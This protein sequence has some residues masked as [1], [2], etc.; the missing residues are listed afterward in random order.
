M[1][2]SIRQALKYSK[3]SDLISKSVNQAKFIQKHLN[4]F[5]AFESEDIL[6]KFSK[7][8]DERQEKE[9]TLS[10]IDGL[11]FAI[12]DNFC[13]K[14]LNTTCCSKILEPFIPKYDATVVAKTRNGGGLILGKVSYIILF[15]LFYKFFVGNIILQPLH[16]I[17]WIFNMLISL[18]NLVY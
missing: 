1:A 9:E 6:E 5:T 17:P 18:K 15:Y 8:A 4:A 11:P 13:T 12:K 14:N 2:L 3:P 10:P 7:E 16:R